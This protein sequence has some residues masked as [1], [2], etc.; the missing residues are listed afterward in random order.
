MYQCSE[1]AALT[2]DLG[3]PTKSIH[4]HT[5]TEPQHTHTQKTKTH[6][7]TLTHTHARTRES[8][9]YAPVYTERKIDKSSNR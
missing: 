3:V 4:K 7:H 8:S 6:T 9:M 5:G 2:M 1:N